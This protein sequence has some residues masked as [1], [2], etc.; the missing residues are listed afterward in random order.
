MTAT[1]ALSPSPILSLLIAANAASSF[2]SM[3]SAGS[4][5]PQ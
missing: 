1:A 3:A 4:S 5:Y 2:M